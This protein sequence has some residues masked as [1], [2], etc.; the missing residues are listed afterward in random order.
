MREN[1][2]GSL[3]LTSPSWQENCGKKAHKKIELRLCTA[4]SDQEASQEPP[5]FSVGY[6]KIT[7]KEGAEG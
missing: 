4:V 1:T 5:S 6:N 7:W 3:S 2:V